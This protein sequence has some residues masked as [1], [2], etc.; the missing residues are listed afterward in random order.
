[1]KINGGG[2][3]ADIIRDDFFKI[4]FGFLILALRLGMVRYILRRAGEVPVSY[5]NEL[6]SRGTYITIIGL[7]V[8]GLGI[9]RGWSSAEGTEGIVMITAGAGTAVLLGLSW[10]LQGIVQ[11]GRGTLR[12]VSRLAGV[13][14]IIGVVLIALYLNAVY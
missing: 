7:V 9:V 14:A 10:V 6:I 1:M 13:T 11:A 3:M 12:S 4:G 2:K 8:V 5:A